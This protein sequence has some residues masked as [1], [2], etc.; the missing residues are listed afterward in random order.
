MIETSER[1]E[2]GDHTEILVPDEHAGTRIDQLLATLLPERSRSFIQR[3]IKAGRVRVDGAPVKASVIARA[4]TR[5]VVDVPA[6]TS[7]TPDPEA[8]PLDIVHQDADVVVVNKSP[9]MV[10]HPAAGHARGTLV[11]ALLHH[12]R[13]LSGIGGEQRPGIVHRLDKGTS[14]LLVAAKHDQAHREL[15]RQFRDREID[16]EY[17]V[18]VWGR[19]Q[20][21]R[22]IDLPIGRN[23]VARQRMSTRAR[24]AKAAVTHIVKAELLDGLTLAGVAIAAGRT[25]Q[26]RVHLA[27]ISHPV[28]GDAIYGGI[29]RRLAPRHRAVAQLSRPFLHASRLAFAHPRDGRRVEFRAPLPEDLQRVLRNLRHPS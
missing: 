14:G 15:G 28:V 19:V 13:D 1:D 7:P 17:T 2:T 25:H 4:K 9:G 23:Q 22:R 26:I 3:L 10:V 8:L 21:G 12:V 16:K 11:N 29:R 20:A 5:I 27:A 24:R 6:L 18:L